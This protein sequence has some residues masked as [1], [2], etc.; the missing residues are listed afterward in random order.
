MGEALGPECGMIED[1]K[2]AVKEASSDHT[3][4]PS[5]GIKVNLALPDAIDICG[6]T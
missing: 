3:G 2:R 5:G 1:K 4:P 6:R